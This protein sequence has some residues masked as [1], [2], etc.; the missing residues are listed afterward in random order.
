[1]ARIVDI[2]EVYPQEEYERDQG[3]FSVVHHW[4][5]MM[6]EILERP[7]EYQ[8]ADGVA[9]SF[10]PMEMYHTRYRPEVERVL[11]IDELENLF[12]NAVYWNILSR[13][14]AYLLNVGTNTFHARDRYIRRIRGVKDAKSRYEETCFFVPN[15]GMP[16][17]E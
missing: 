2:D 13:R 16:S 3:H 10:A 12:S 7:V 1:M 17:A 15:Q 11:E 6:S 8:E 9:Y 14:L 4:Q 5:E